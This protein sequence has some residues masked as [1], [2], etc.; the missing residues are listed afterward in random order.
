MPWKVING[1]TKRIFSH[2]SHFVLIEEHVRN[3]ICHG[4]LAPRLRTH[5][6]PVDDLDLEEDVVRLLKE[7]LVVLVLLTERGW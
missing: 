6:V 4:K 1:G 5:Q 2:H 3:A 7:L